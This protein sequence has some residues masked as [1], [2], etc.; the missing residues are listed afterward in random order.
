MKQQ[1]VTK[2]PLKKDEPLK[3]RVLT[4][5]RSIKENKTW[6]DHFSMPNQ[7]HLQPPR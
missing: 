6:Y 1:G 3:E 5:L 2:N 4:D 7:L